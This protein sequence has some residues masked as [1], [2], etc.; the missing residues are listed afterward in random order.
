MSLYTFLYKG[1]VY[2]TVTVANA[3]P[4]VNSSVESVTAPGGEFPP[5]ANPATADPDPV[6]LA[7]ATAK[8]LTSD[9]E[10]PFQASVFP[11][12]QEMHYLQKPVQK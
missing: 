1:Q 4:A 11:L 10:E 5:A 7:L 3:L 12:F 6:A 9:Q 8:S 2:D